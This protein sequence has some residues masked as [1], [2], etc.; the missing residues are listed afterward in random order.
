MCSDWYKHLNTSSQ[1]SVALIYIF[2]YHQPGQWHWFI[3]LNTPNKGSRI[4]YTIPAQGQHEKK[5]SRERCRSSRI[6][7][8]LRVVA[9]THPYYSWL[10]SA[11]CCNISLK[12]RV[13]PRVCTTHSQI[14]HFSLKVSKIIAMTSC[15]I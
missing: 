8:L 3:H 7:K 15:T 1:C 9:F 6:I 11:C 12:V 4:E 10:Y 14:H 5:T 13:R 2:K